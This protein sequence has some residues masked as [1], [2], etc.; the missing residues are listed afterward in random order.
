[1]KDKPD[2]PEV[3]GVSYLGTQ[4][5]PEDVHG[6]YSMEGSGALPALP[7]ER[8]FFHLFQAKCQD[9]VKVY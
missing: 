5:Y 7:H 2:I 8:P 4:S 1:M 6:I 9:E 3:S